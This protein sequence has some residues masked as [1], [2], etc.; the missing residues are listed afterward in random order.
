MACNSC[1]FND[2]LTQEA[3]YVQNMGCLPSSYDIIN[4]KKETGHNWACHSN[5]EKICSGL[6]ET[7]KEK[8]LGLNMKSGGLYLQPGSNCSQ[9]SWAPKDLLPIIKNIND[10]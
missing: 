7:N 2:G 9:K 8:N 1:P 6:K 3:S 4:L 10:Y 5:N